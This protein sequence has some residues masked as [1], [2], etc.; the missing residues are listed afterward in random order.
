MAVIVFGR[1]PF[2]ARVILTKKD[3]N[4]NLMSVSMN[5]LKPLTL[6]VHMKWSTTEI[7]RLLPLVPGTN[8]MKCHV[9][10]FQHKKKHFLCDSQSILFGAFR[11]N[12]QKI[13]IYNCLVK[14]RFN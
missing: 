3:N 4:L 5:I 10:F 13:I 2:Q 9:D 11:A 1:P 7:C 12:L 6:I 14:F 8:T